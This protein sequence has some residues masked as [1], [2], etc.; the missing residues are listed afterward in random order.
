MRVR[1]QNNASIV[2]S[3]RFARST[4]RSSTFNRR[5][6]YWK[7]MS[8]TK[9]ADGVLSSSK[10]QNCQRQD[11]L[12][13]GYTNMFLSNSGLDPLRG[14]A[15]SDLFKFPAG[16]SFTDIRPSLLLSKCLTFAIKC[17]NTGEEFQRRACST[18]AIASHGAEPCAAHMVRHVAWAQNKKS[19]IQTL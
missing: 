8:D 17:S 14:T 15:A 4:M 9:K 12:K 5:R 1:F 13:K 10:H 19:R 7:T 18:L 6:I 11:D 3:F 2:R 16:Y